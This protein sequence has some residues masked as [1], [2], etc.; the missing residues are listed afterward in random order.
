MKPRREYSWKREIKLARRA[1]NVMQLCNYWRCGFWFISLE[2]SAEAV[3]AIIVIDSVLPTV[4]L[5]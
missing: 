4:Q 3:K 1:R 5:R 2:A